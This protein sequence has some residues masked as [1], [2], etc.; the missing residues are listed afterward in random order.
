MIISQKN[1]NICGGA[2]KSYTGAFRKKGIVFEISTSSPVQKIRNVADVLIKM[3]FRNLLDLSRII[4]FL[5]SFAV[6]AVLCSQNIYS[7]YTIYINI[8]YKRFH[9]T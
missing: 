3:F 9:I 8:C 7:L 4:P 2:N 5:I 1:H 6:M